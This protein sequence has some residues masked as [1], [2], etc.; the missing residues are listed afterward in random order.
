[1]L[2]GR[3]Q[4]HRLQY[5]LTGGSHQTGFG[6]VT[7]DFDFGIAFV[8]ATPVPVIAQTDNRRVVTRGHRHLDEHI[9]KLT[10]RIDKAVAFTGASA[11]TA[12]AELQPCGR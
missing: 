12:V 1:M 11:K 3:L 10:A 9:A 8:F 4:H 7:V 5:T 2:I 6:A